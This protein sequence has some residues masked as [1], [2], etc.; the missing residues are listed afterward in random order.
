MCTETLH[1]WAQTIR[2]FRFL[3]SATHRAEHKDEWLLSGAWRTCATK[4]PVQIQVK[5]IFKTRVPAPSRV[6]NLPVS[7]VWGFSEVTVPAVHASELTFI[8]CTLRTVL[9]VFAAD[10]E[11]PVESWSPSSGLLHPQGLAQTGSSVTNKLIM[12]YKSV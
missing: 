11:H 8:P 9:L 6:F 2:L 10:C 1:H 3:L 4:N 5:M 7:S 12:R